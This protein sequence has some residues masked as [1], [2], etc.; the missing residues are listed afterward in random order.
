MIMPFQIYRHF[1]GNLYL[2]IA[3]ALSESTLEP[4]VVYMSLEG[5][6]KVWTRSM[7][8]FESLVPEDRENPTGQKHRF[9][10][11]KNIRSVLSQ[12]TTKSLIYELKSRPDSPFNETDF[13][14]LND[15]VIAREYLLANMARNPDSGEIIALDITVAGDSY[16]S[17]KKFAENNPHRCNSRTKILKRLLVEVESFD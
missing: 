7:S 9:E 2:V 16:D 15:K 6:N 11:V 1:K 14:G 3:T 17:V 12:C 4:T 13:E 10:L 5:D 8:D